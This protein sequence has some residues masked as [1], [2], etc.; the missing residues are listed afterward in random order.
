[1]INKITKYYFL[2]LYSI[3]PITFIIGPSASLLNVILIDLSFLILLFKLKK[4]EFLNNKVFKCLIL[5]YAY[6]IFNSII[7][8]NFDLGL[9]RNL[10]F[11]RIIILF[12]SFNFFFLEKDFFNKVFLFWSIV[13]FIVLL[14]VY[15]ESFT[16]RNI[17]GYGEEFGRRIVSFF[18][19]EPI[20]GGFINSFFLIILGFLFDRS[21]YKYKNYLF[22]FALFILTAILLTGERSNSI[23]SILALSVFFMMVKNITLANK[24]KSISIVVV[25]IAI[26]IFSSEY[27]KYRFIDQ[28]I[29]TFFVKKMNSKDNQINPYFQLQKSGYEVFKDN[30][31][32]GVGNKNYRYLTC[33]LNFKD[34]V[35]KQLNNERYIC[36]THPHQ[37]Y[38]EF[39]SEHGLIGSLIILYIFYIIIFSK[40]RIFLKDFKYIQLGTFIYLIFAF[41]PL[42]PSGAFFSDYLLTIFTINLSIFYASNS[43]LNIF[44]NNKKKNKL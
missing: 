21:N 19:D 40:W 41:S 26:S 35:D 36:S 37:T 15:L 20:V 6:L 3:I 43:N 27:L 44:L 12:I 28:P 13:I 25:L 32:F 18:K 38:L 10:G 16:G 1:M 8:I 11:V 17:F 4:F 39:L 22:L 23:K 24:I 9:H 30:L 5:L 31:L 14:D 2:F 42:L 29:S 7:S 34:T 33:D